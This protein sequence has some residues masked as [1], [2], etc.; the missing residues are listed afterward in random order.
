M[1][2]VR[3]TVLKREYYEDLLKAHYAPDAGE[4]RVGRCSVFTDGQVFETN[5]SCE[6]PDGFCDWAWA[7]IQRDVIS[8]AFG[9]GHP[10]A[11][12]PP[13]AI[14]CCTDGKRPVIFKIEPL[15]ERLT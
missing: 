15:E 1:S 3:I 10:W 8:V 7:D 4:R 9:V 14:A 11:S 5:R 2:R 12:P 6:K 13:M